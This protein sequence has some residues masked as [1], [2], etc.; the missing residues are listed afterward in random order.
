MSQVNLK[1]RPAMILKT[2]NKEKRTSP[3]NNNVIELLKCKGQVVHITGCVFPSSAGTKILAR[4]KAGL[5]DFRFHYL[6]HT[7]AIKLV[8]SGVRLYVGKGLL[9][10]KTITMTMRYAHHCPVSLKHGEEVLDKAAD[11]SVDSGQ[12]NGYAVLTGTPQAFEKK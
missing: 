2:K 6:R 1:M 8:Q 5:E 7:F 9:G 11:T 10:H 3:L 12:K 4:K